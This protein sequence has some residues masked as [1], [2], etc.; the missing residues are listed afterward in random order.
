MIKVIVII[1]NFNGGEKVLELVKNL[2]DF[3]SVA[4]IVVADN[5]SSDSSKVRIQ[6]LVKGK[7]NITVLENSTNLGFA[8]GVNR[9]AKAALEQG[10]E[11]VL[12]LNP[13]AQIGESAIQKLVEGPGDVVSP[14]LTFSRGG[15]KIFDLGGKINWF[16]GRPKHSE[17]TNSELRTMNIVTDIDFVSG[18]CMLIRKTVFEKVGFLDEHY[19][20]YFEDVDFCHRAKLAGFSVVVNHDVV[21]T[22]QIAEHRVTNDQFKRKQILKSNFLFVNKWV[23]WYVRPLAWG[24]LLWLKIASVV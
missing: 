1:V 22:H 13:D 3:A 9:G 11:A 20:L 5:A 2:A 4:G 21:V 15:E 14:I 23:P 6:E 10:A 12:L 24:Y 18:A 17:T 7:K 8:A 19:F 16:I